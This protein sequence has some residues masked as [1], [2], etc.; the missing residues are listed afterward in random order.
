MALANLPNTIPDP[1]EARSSLRFS[2]RFSRRLALRDFL[3]LFEL[4]DSGAPIEIL[5][6]P[7][8]FRLEHGACE[9]VTVSSSNDPIVVSFARVLA[10]LRPA[11]DDCVHSHGTSFVT[12]PG[13]M[14]SYSEILLSRGELV[15]TGSFVAHNAVGSCAPPSGICS[16]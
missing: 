6:G 7:K 14:R 11:I 13:S 16:E 5:A 10:G 12:S 9:A 4:G 1:V 2:L 3:G 8:V 15:E